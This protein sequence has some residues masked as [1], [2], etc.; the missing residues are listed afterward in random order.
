MTRRG[1]THSSGGITRKNPVTG[2]DQRGLR[3]ARSCNSW[4]I[5]GWWIG[6]GLRQPTGVGSLSGAAAH[7]IIVH[8]VTVLFAAIFECQSEQGGIQLCRCLLGHVFEVDGRAARHVNQLADCRIVDFTI[9]ETTPFKRF[10]VL[11]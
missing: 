8:S 5:A 6:V 1:E 9:P 4:T 2:Q 10:F 7:S 3:F 11:G